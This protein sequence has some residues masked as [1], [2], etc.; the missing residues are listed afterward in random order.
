M[1]KIDTL[2]DTFKMRLD[3]FII[4]C[5]S[6]EEIEKWDIDTYGDLDVYCL[7]EFISTILRLIMSDKEISEKEVDYLNENFGFSYNVDS[8][9][10]VYEN[11]EE[12]FSGSAFHERIREDIELLSAV[13]TELAEEF[14]ELLRLICRIIAA[15]DELFTEEEQSELQTVEDLLKSSVC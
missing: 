13:N 6:L 4:G 14:K 8:L 2:T 11:C 10:D 9:R 1:K 15:S 12:V 3:A 5:D 7:N